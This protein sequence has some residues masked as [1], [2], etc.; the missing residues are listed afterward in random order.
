MKAIE[1]F[2]GVRGGPA[3]VIQKAE[4][5]PGAAILALADSEAML[6][7]V[8]KTELLVELDRRPS[9]SGAGVKIRRL[10]VTWPNGST[11]SFSSL[12]WGEEVLIGREFAFL[13]VPA[14]VVLTDRLLAYISP[15]PR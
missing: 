1:T 2:R 11:C 10:A 5:N 7:S 12:S 9:A 3:W 4:E 14:S 13:W 8:M 6:L 15:R